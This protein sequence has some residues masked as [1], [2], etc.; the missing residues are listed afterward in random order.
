MTPATHHKQQFLISWYHPSERAIALEAHWWRLGRNEDFG[1]E[2]VCATVS[3]D[4]E[5]AAR[6][7]ICQSYGDLPTPVHFRF[8]TPDS[9]QIVSETWCSPAKP[10]RWHRTASTP[11]REVHALG[12]A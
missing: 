6:E 5:A 10:Q 1:Y 2:V 12:T 4:N 11:D 3:T 8:C 7:L 9:E